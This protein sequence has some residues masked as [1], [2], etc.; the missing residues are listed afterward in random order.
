MPRRID[1]SRAS[2]PSRAGGGGVAAGAGP[3]DCASYAHTTPH[4][5]Y[6]PVT[7]TKR[8]ISICPLG[9]VP[10]SAFRPPLP[11][12]LPPS[13][14]S[15]CCWQETL[16]A[17]AGGGGGGGSI[18]GGGNG[19]GGGTPG[20][21]TPGSGGGGGRPPGGGGGGGGG[22]GTPGTRGKKGEGWG[23]GMECKR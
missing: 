11:R 3:S 13:R 1:S 2:R 16:P 17:T 10:A 4:P 20:E 23:V 12:S 14:Q 21:P 15:P 5:S 7:R 8:N 9:A 6:T 19:G 22:G 18:P